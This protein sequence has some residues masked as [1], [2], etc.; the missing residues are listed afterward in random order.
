MAVSPGESSNALSL[1][2][3][4]AS[5]VRVT[6]SAV[7]LAVSVMGTVPSAAGAPM[8]KVTV[9]AGSASADV[10]ARS[11]KFSARSPPAPSRISRSATQSEPSAAQP[12]GARIDGHDGQLAAVKSTVVF[13]HDHALAPAPR[14][15]DTAV[16]K[17]VAVRVP[18][19]KWRNASD[20]VPTSGPKALSF[21]TKSRAA[22][23]ATMRTSV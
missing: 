16:A 12:A 9:D 15:R 10:C 14:G 11:T 2:R 17:G 4:C 18:V 13:T 7:A 23:S 19:D 20:V 5:V 6:K 22:S 1:K 21:L 3:P 8:A